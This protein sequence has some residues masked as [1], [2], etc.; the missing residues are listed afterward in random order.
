[1]AKTGSIAITQGTGSVSTNKTLITVTGKITTS[2]ESY[3]GSHR[4][5]SITVTQDG[6][7]IYSGTFT[8]GAPANS[9]TTLFSISLYVTHKADGSSGTIATSYNYDSGWCTASTSKTLTKI[10]RYATISNAPNFTNLDN[11]KITYSN[12]A[13]SLVTSLQ[14]CISLTGAKDDVPYRNIPINGTSY[15]F[16]L[17]DAER[18]TLMEATTGNPPS[19]TVT[20]FVR[21]ILAGVTNHSTLSKT[22]SVSDDIKPSATV[23]LSDAEGYFEK[24]GKYIQGK[25]KLRVSINAAGIYGSAIKSYR[26]TFEGKTYTTAE[27]TTDV[28]SGKDTLNLEIVVTDSRGR[29]CTVR[30]SVKVYEYSPPKITSIKAKRCQQHNVSLIGDEYL[31]VLFDVVVTTLDDKNTA[32]YELDYK[33]TTED[34][35][36]TLALEDYANQYSV[37][38]GNAIFAADD[39]A[40]NIILRITDNFGSVERKINGPCISVLISKLKYNLGLA[41]G[42]LAELSGVLDIGFKTRFFGGILHMVLEDSA[43][44]DEVLTPNKY[45]VKAGHTYEGFPESAVNA[46]LDVVGDDEIMKQTFSVISKTN[47]RTYERVFTYADESWSSWI[48]LSG[49]FVIEQGKNGIW[50][51]RKWSSGVAECWGSTTIAGVVCSN[52]NGVLYY[53]DVKSVTF[54]FTFS[55]IQYANVASADPWRVVGNNINFNTTTLTFKVVQAHSSTTAYDWVGRI[56]VIGRWKE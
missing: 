27:F 1:M 41:F 24:Y 4:T 54:P 19:R 18:K 22:F 29:T 38:D 12:P 46:V 52:T 34:V 45:L 30:E 42:K 32:T 35:Y 36:I 26:T 39:D 7:K 13:G 16:T 20:F 9:T 31:G 53:S 50:T 47:P 3:R 8:S 43:K 33:K 14:A 51:Y 49:D 44:A 37:T 40:Y 5:G 6:T 2:G 21:T 17:T 10:P 25:S 56:S 15:Q 48:C 55:S 11:P 23:E 28:I